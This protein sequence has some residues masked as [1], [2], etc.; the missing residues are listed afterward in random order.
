M[1]S[2]VRRRRRPEVPA[3]PKVLKHLLATL[4]PHWQGIVSDVTGRS[5][6]NG[7]RLAFLYDTERVKPSGVVAEIVLPPIEDDPAPDATMVSGGWS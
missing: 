2:S 3:Q 4:G 1:I 5:A 6:G 7:D